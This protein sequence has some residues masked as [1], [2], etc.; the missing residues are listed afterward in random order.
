M[1]IRIQKGFW[2]STFGLALL[3]TV[4]AVFLICTSVFAWYYVKYAR[5]IDARLSGHVLQSTTQIFS[6]PEQISPGQN[7]SAEDLTQ[8]LQRAGYRPQADDGSLGQYTVQGSTVDVRPSKLSY[9]AGGNAIAVKF[10][11]KAIQS[12]RPLSGGAELPVA[13]IEPE[14][15]TNLFD[16]AR[17][18]RRAVRYEDLP[19]TLV[20]AIL[21]AE[22]KRFFEHPG[23][24]FIRIMGAAWNDLRHGTH[25]Q[26]A[27]TI[28]MQVARTFFLSTDRNW[29]RKLS[30]AMLSLELE[31]RFNKQQIFE[32]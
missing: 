23:F 25:L 15:I 19:P 26:G 3:G 22:D 31:Q 32:M 9:F 4:F 10:A 5:M 7:W 20:N 12:I 27:S 14:L 1:R 28:T 2:T 21:S 11:G 24:D 29:R 8:F 13:E 17:E 6:A 18:K 30:E 16:S